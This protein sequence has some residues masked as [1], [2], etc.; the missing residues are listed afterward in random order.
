MDKTKTMQHRI[1]HNTKNKQKKYQ[2]NIYIY[3][4][5]YE[6]NKVACILKFNNEL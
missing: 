3:K 2:K 5:W 1:N 4:H 6:N